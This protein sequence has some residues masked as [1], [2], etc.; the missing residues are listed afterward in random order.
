ML[1]VLP[2]IFYFSFLP[3]SRTDRASQK[4]N[5][6]STSL[7]LA[8]FTLGKWTSY[9]CPRTYFFFSLQAIQVTRTFSVFQ[10]SAAL[11]RDSVFSFTK[12][13]CSCCREGKPGWSLSILRKVLLALLIIMEAKNLTKAEH[14]PRVSETKSYCESKPCRNLNPLPVPHLF[15]SLNSTR[16]T[17][18][19]T[20]CFMFFVFLSTKSWCQK[21]FPSLRSHEGNAG[22]APL[23]TV[24]VRR[25]IHYCWWRSAAPAPHLPKRCP[26]KE[27][28]FQ[29]YTSRSI[30]VLFLALNYKF[31]VWRTCR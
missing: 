11:W 24:A 10:S 22:W 5:Q 23:F 12:V 31:L 18:W 25:G 16:E 17:F 8:L 30:F 26:N 4:I 14:P 19:G 3:Q 27:E 6:M 2:L 7:D 20:Q 15:D 21:W 28:Y 13:S 9:I 29:T 1:N